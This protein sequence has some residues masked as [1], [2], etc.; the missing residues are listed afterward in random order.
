MAATME[1]E[2]WHTGGGQQRHA[3]ELWRGRKRAAQ[4]PWRRRWRGH[5]R[6]RCEDD[7]RGSEGFV[8]DGG[9]SATVSRDSCCSFVIFVLILM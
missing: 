1:K 7:A 5:A 4:R 6:S 3:V 8:R 9:G 2:K